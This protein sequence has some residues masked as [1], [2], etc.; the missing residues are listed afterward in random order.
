MYF[1]IQ[2]NMESL[3]NHGEF[4]QL[5]YEKC[6]AKNITFQWDTDVKQNT[7]SILQCVLDKKLFCYGRIH[8]NGCLSYFTLLYNISSL[9]IWQTPYVSQKKITILKTNFNVIYCK[10]ITAWQLKGSLPE[11]IFVHA[12]YWNH[13]LIDEICKHLM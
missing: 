13:S 6:S 3:R 9:L 2:L 7:I 8:L 4:E 11:N 12:P 10:L 1:V 5:L